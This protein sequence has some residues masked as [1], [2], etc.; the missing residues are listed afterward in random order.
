MFKQAAK[1]FVYP[2]EIFD[3]HVLL[4]LDGQVLLLDSGSPESFGNFCTL[5]IAGKSFS[6]FESAALTDQVSKL[7]GKTIDALI[8]NGVLN[9]FCVHYDY[10]AAQV[11]FYDH[12]PEFSAQY[13]EAALLNSSQ[14]LQDYHQ[15]PQF[16]LLVDKKPYVCL[17]DSGAKIS[18]IQRDCIDNESNY[19]EVVD[20]FHLSCGKF[21]TKCRNFSASV[22]DAEFAL[23]LGNLPLHIEQMLGSQ[24]HCILGYDLLRQFEVV[25][26]PF[27]ARL[28]LR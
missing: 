24:M 28:L 2:V 6:L 26:D 11:S 3:G 10:A 19:E 20:D 16:E 27:K 7:V 5:D 14:E 12:S 9:R 23:K 17:F 25:I 1:K 21:T 22:A 15:I 18:Y 4:N 13:R 8:G